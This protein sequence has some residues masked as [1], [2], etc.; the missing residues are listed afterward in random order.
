MFLH[1]RD[2]N[3]N[4]LRYVF[5]QAGQPPNTSALPVLPVTAETEP[6]DTAQGW[7]SLTIGTTE[8]GITG[9][10]NIT[11]SNLNGNV[12]ISD[13]DAGATVTTKSAILQTT[14]SGV[15]TVGGVAFTVAGDA[16]GVTFTTDTEGK[17]TAINGL[18]AGA[19][20]TFDSS[21]L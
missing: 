13:L 12:V 8:L 11:F 10:K 1:I 3:C 15:F 4:L 17:V 7:F 20:V 6:S 2:R 18:K 5:P 9:D 14:G 16:N 21:N 19:T